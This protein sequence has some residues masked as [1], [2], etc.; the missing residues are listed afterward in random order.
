MSKILR[1]LFQ[2]N[3]GKEDCAVAE[4]HFET[5]PSG[6]NEIKKISVCC[7]KDQL[8]VNF[9]CLL[10]YKSFFLY[11]SLAGNILVYSL[12]TERSPEFCKFFE[13]EVTGF[14]TSFYAYHCQVSNLYLIVIC[15]C[16]FLVATLQFYTFS[17]YLIRAVWLASKMS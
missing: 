4:L 9:N 15:I 1:L 10:N 6:S 3:L 5:I 2:S 8:Q 7:D 14:R 12:D 17:S 13:I 11:S 16:I